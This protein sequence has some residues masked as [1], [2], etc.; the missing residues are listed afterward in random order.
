MPGFGA[1]DA[2]DCPDCQGKGTM[3]VTRRTPDPER[4]QYERQTFRCAKC[5]KPLERTVDEDGNPPSDAAVA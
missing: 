1:L 5:Q 2:L 4:P 3:F